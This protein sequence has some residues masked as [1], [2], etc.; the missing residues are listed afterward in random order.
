MS[1]YRII[2]EEGRSNP[3]YGMITGF[4]DYKDM[5]NCQF[6]PFFYTFIPSFK[7]HSITNLNSQKLDLIMTSRG[8]DNNY[9][10]NFMSM[11]YSEN[12]SADGKYSNNRT[13]KF[14]IVKPDTEVY[15]YNL[16]KFV[17]DN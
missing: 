16:Y 6:D 1:D 14:F 5:V 4:R 13:R 17:R 3:V 15:L 7:K 9:P 8:I 2:R 10:Y 12:Y 11:Y